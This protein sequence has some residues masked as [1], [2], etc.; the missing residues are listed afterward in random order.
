MVLA[1]IFR[2]GDDFDFRIGDVSKEHKT[3]VVTELSF[4]EQE[5]ILRAR[6]KEEVN[7]ILGSKIKRTYH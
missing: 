4:Q 6:T 3:C 1:T 7:D 5:K 2:V